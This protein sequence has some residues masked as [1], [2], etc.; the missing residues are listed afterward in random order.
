MII[1][2]DCE[3][4]DYGDWSE[5]SESCGTGTEFRDR[6]VKISAQNGGEA[7]TGEAREQKECNTH[8]CAGRLMFYSFVSFIHMHCR[9]VDNI[10]LQKQKV[11]KIITPYIVAKRGLLNKF[12]I[13]GQILSRQKIS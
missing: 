8:P 3:W 6:A 9:F 2:V 11:K 10:I 13:E 7:C 1:L 5:C 12:G 4:G